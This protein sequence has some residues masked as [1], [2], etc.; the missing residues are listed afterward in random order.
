MS[1]PE[2]GPGGGLRHLEGEPP[3][4]GEATEIA[5]GVLWVRLPLP[6]ALDHVNV[7]ALDDGDGWTIVDTGVDSKR[8][9]A[10]WEGLLAGPLGG[11]PV[12]RVLLT[13]HHP[14]HVGLAGWFAARGAGVAASRTSW[15]LAR[16][17]VL[18]EQAVPDAPTLAYWRSAGM[19]EDV[20]EARRSGRPF[21]F[22]DMVHPIP[23]GFERVEDGEP[24][25][26]GGRDWMVHYGGGHAPD[27][28][29]LWS[30]SDDLA[31]VGDQ[32]LP[33]ISPNIG[34]YATEP[35]ADPLADWLDAC[36]DLMG[37]AEA[38]HL[39]LP[40][41]GMPFTGAP[42]RLAQLI[43]NHHGALDRLKGWLTEPRTAAECFAPLFRRRIAEGEYGLALVE[44]VAHLNHL[45]Y[46]GQAVREDEDGVWRWRL[47]PQPRAVSTGD[48]AAAAG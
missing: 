46:L 44:S 24:F 27:H 36:E 43:D 9:R 23:L 10:I 4:E 21:N 22:A 16:M 20:L 3:A 5:D 18:D 8:T 35:G 12:R 45:L 48:S 40:G 15:L 29:T 28:L 37:V 19:A 42:T 25:A 33:G 7:Y 2:D 32:I 38:R 47:A 39:V 17:L 41:H 30:M 6:M 26:A 34:V 11:R 31:I 13:H 14:D 1:G